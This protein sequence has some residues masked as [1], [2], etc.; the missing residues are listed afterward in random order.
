MEPFELPETDFE[1]TETVEPLVIELHRAKP[2]V[3]ESAVLSTD[4]LQQ[5]ADWI[6]EHGGAV[7]V[8]ADQLIIQTLE[9]PFTVRVGDRVVRGASGFRRED[10]EIYVAEHEKV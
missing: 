9:G 5:V 2:V 3:R 4:N 7:K 1:F 10:P 6:T 8:G